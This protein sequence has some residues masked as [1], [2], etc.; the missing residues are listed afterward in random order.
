MAKK[1]SEV[2]SSAEFKALS[3]EDRELARNEYFDTVVAPQVLLEEVDMARSEFDSATK[4]TFFDGVNELAGQAK[5]N[6]VSAVTNPLGREQAEEPQPAQ[7]PSME[8]ADRV[9]SNALRSAAGGDPAHAATTAMQAE[10][11]KLVPVTVKAGQELDW[12]KQNRPDALAKLQT[13]TGKSAANAAIAR[14]AASFDRTVEAMRA[15]PGEEDSAWEYSVDQA[16]QLVG[17]GA[18]AVGGAFGLKNIERAG[19]EYAE[20]QEQDI[21]LGGYK[22]DPASI[23]ERFNEEGFVGALK[24]VGTRIAENWAPG[25]VAL[26]GSAAAALT[27]VFSAPAATV[28]AGATAG[29]AGLMGVGEVKSELED[30]G[31]E[32]GDGLAVGAGALI[33]LLDMVGAGKV[34]PRDMLTRMT[35]NEIVTALVEK[36]YVDAAKAFAKEIG[37]KAAYEGL[38][39]MAQEGV[40]MGAAGM[41]GAEYE[42]MEVIDRLIDGAVIGA[43]MGGG[44]GTV[45]TGVETRAGTIRREV[46]ARKAALRQELGMP[47]P[48]AQ[49]VAAL[50]ADAT[51]RI[52]QAIER[53]QNVQNATPAARTQAPAQTAPVEAP[54]P[55]RGD[56]TPA[57]VLPDAGGSGDVQAAGLT[58][59]DLVPATTEAPQATTEAAPVTPDAPV[60]GAITDEGTKPDV[61]LTNEGKTPILQN[62]NRATPSSIAQMQSIAG[63]PDYGRMGF[64]RDF[65]NGAPVVAGGQI[66]PE[67]LGRQDVAVASDGRRIPVQYA[68]VEAADVLPSNQADGTPNPDYGNQSVQRI[69]A[70]AGNGRI[71]GLQL[72]YRKGT[73]PSYLQELANDTLHGVS[74]DVIRAMR[75]PVLVRV[76]P[77]DQV[78]ADIGDVSNTVGNLNLSAVEQANNDSQRVNLDALQFAEDGSITPEAVRQFVRAMPQAEQGGLIDTNGQPS[79]QAVDRIN[80]AVFAKAYGNDQLVRLYAQAQDPEARNVLSALA[81]VAPKMARLEGAGALDIRG[82]V[83]QAAEIAVNARREGKALSLAAQQLDLAADPD[84]GKL[85]DLF[86]RNARTVKPVVE[87]LS[88]AA[89]FA[90][91]EANK[92]GEDMFGEVPRASRTDIINQLS[93]Q[94]ERASQE[95]LED[96]AGRQPVGQDAGRQTPE[97][98]GPAAPAESE[99]G[100]PAADQAADQPASQPALS[101]YTPEEVTQRLERLEQAERERQQQERQADQRERADRERDSFTLTGS[102]RAADANPGQADIFNQPAREARPSDVSDGSN[103]AQEGTPKWAADAYLRDEVPDGWYVHGRGGRQDLNTG[104]VIQMTRSWEVAD[105]YAKDRGSRWIIRPSSDAIVLDLS[106][107]HTSDMDRVVAAA[108]DDFETGAHD[109]GAVVGD[110]ESSIGRDADTADIEAAIRSSFSPENIVN[111]A[112]AYDNWSWAGWLADAL[113]VDFV[114]VKGGAVAIG[115]YAVDAVKVPADPNDPN[116]R[117]KIE[118]PSSAYVA[119]PGQPGYTDPYGSLETRP[120]TRPKQLEAGRAALADIERRILGQRAGVLEAATLLGSAISRD[121][122]AAGGVSLVGRVARTAQDLAAVAQVLRDP[123]FETFRVFYTDKS[124]KIVGERA[125]S[126][127][128]AGVTY[129]PGNLAALIEQDMARLKAPGY[130][131][132]HNHP[133]G[134]ARE[135]DADIKSTNDLAL[136]APGLLGHVIIDHN[137]YNH[138]KIEQIGG[139]TGEVIKAPELA[140]I[141]LNANHE[142]PHPLLGELILSPVHLATIGKRLQKKDGYAVLIGTS[143]NGKIQMLTEV[144]ANLLKTGRSSRVAELRAVVAIKRAAGETGSYRLFAVVPGSLAE[145]R[146]A[147]ESGLFIDVVDVDSRS[148]IKLGLTDGKD[149]KIP[150]SRVEQRGG[151]SFVNQLASEYRAKQTD[152]AAFRKWFGDS[153][154]VDANGKPLVVYHGGARGITEFDPGAVGS[155]FGYDTEGFFFTTERGNRPGTA[156]N[157]AGPDG[158]VYPVYLALQRPY[159]LEQFAA[160]LGLTVGD[161]VMQEG[162]PQSP[163][164]VFDTD[165]A[166]I[167]RRVR[168]G[169]YDGVAFDVDYGDGTREAMYVALQPTQVKS[170][171]G[172]RG[173]FDPGS[174]NIVESPSTPYGASPAPTRPQQIVS[175]YRAKQ[176]DTEAFRRWFKDSKVVDADGK[177]LVVYHGTGV[178]VGNHGE[179]MSGDFDTFLPDLSGKSSKTG[180]PSGTFFFTDDPQVASSYTVQW[181][182]DFSEKYKDNANVMPVYLSLKKPLKVSAKGENWRDILYKGEYRDINEIA[183]LAKESGKYDGVIVTRVKDHGVGRTSGKPSTTYI[184]FRPEQIK[185][186]TGNRGTFD[187][188]DPSIV[189]EESEAY[190]AQAPRRPYTDD[191]QLQ[192]FLDRGPVESQAG[193]AAVAAQRAAVSAVDDIR[194]TGTILGLALSGD[195]AA[196][197]RVSLVGQKVGSAE[198]LA[199][200]AQVYRDPRFETFRVVFV[201]DAGKVV[202]QVGLTSRLPAAAP[203]IMGND[204]DQYL[205]GLMAAARN[206]GASGYYMLHN[207][208][209]GIAKTS[210]ADEMLTSNYANRTFGTDVQFRGH[211]VIDTN[212]YSVINGRGESTLFK[213]DFGQPAPY[214]AQEWEDVSISGPADVM[215]M[216]KR[217]QVDDGAITLIHTDNQYRVKAIS[218]IPNDASTMSKQELKKL[219]LKASLQTQGA[220]VFA[221]GRDSQALAR[222]GT[223]VVDAIYVKDSGQAQSLRSMGVI[224]GGSP[225]PETR[226]ARLS[227]DS[228]PEFNY[229]RKQPQ[230]APMQRVAEPGADQTQTPEF[231]RWFGNSKV[232]DANGKPLVVYHGTDADF[233]EFSDDKI[234]AATDAGGNGRGFYFA[235]DSG[236]AS[237]YAG[238]KDGANIVPAY[239]S[240][241]NPLR[242]EASGFGGRAAAIRSLGLEVPRGDP[243]GE[244]SSRF[245]AAAKAKGYDGVL[246]TVNGDPIEVV[247]FRPEQIKSAIGNRGTFDPNDPSIVREDGPEYG[248]Q[249][250]SPNR[251]ALGRFKFRLGEVALG[252]LEAAAGPAL[253]FFSMRMASP[254]LRKQLR[255]M[256]ATIDKAKRAAVDVAQ[257]MSALSEADRVM[258]SDIVEKMLAPGVIP[259]EHVVRVADAITRSMDA[260]TDELVEL[261]ML[262]KDSAE[263]WRGRYLPRIY[264]RQTELENDPLVQRL[265]KTGVPTMAGIGGGSLK[266]R[267]MFQDVSVDAVDQW[268]ALGYEV[269]DP[270]WRLNQGKL[271]LNDP[272]APKLAREQVTVWRDWTPSERAQMGEM[273]DAMYRFVMGYTA[274]QRDIAL[275]RLFNNIANNPEWVRRSGSDG[276]VQVPNTEIPDTGGVKLYGNLAGLYVRRDVMSHLTQFEEAANDTLQLYREAMGIWKQGKVALNPVAHFNNIVSNLSMAH[277]AGVSYWDGHKY[278]NA[279]RDLIQNAP[280]VDEARDVG[281]FTGSFTREEM[282]QNLPPELQKMAN[283][284]ESGARKGGRLVLNAMTFWLRKPLTDAYEAEDTFFKYLIYR[285]ARQ[286]GMEPAEAMDYALRY[287]FAYDD[288]PSGARKVRD[289]A[290][291][292]FSYTYKA[293]PALLHT[294]MV[295]PWRLVAPAAL[296]HGINAVAYALA[297]GDEDDD[298]LEKLVKGRELEAEEREAMPDHTRGLSALGTPKTIRLGT[299]EL[300]GLPVF[301][302]ASRAIPGGDMFDM[303]N[304][305][306]GMELPAPLTPNHPILSTFAAM[307]VN[308]EMFLGRNV[309]DDNDT[310]AEKAE[311]RAKWM[312]ILLLPAIAPGGLHSQ[313]LMNATAN[314]M[315]TVITTPLGEFTGVDRSG[316]PVQPKYAAMQT[317]GIKARPVDL[318]LEAQRRGAQEQAL[319]N[320]IA[321]EVRSMARLHQR[322]AVTDRMM[323]ETSEQAREKIERTRE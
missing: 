106:G 126:S 34:I 171:I 156:D 221:V 160:D 257:E 234:G 97:P 125:Y 143:P 136:R 18:Q 240:L 182:G 55:A 284:Q 36:G 162:S 105:Q 147:V 251:D 256:K 144:P 104:N 288:L 103:T 297:A 192:L 92:P 68:V 167:M 217:L 184:A 295:Y 73:T 178:N 321:A 247:A 244:W 302:D 176:T 79:K 260:Q 31:I 108:L 82:V 266:G 319:V 195:Y 63:N 128:M 222:I 303:R 188:N 206:R 44:V 175:E 117:A 170:A 198:D 313:R 38:T 151:K 287:I 66:A 186:A 253:D 81:Q 113:G 5:D 28:L 115:D 119:Q 274:M 21:D 261:G 307:L 130:W 277:F 29:G 67:Q 197:Q 16:Q 24:L 211:V 133:S 245:T 212:E 86:A 190:N 112:E 62:R 46:E 118:A 32:G 218:T 7:Q 72:A 267:G 93:P 248:A 26:A 259:P 153:K 122:R 299:D 95:T 203:G 179:F 194:S 41:K 50:D 135:S 150:V 10:A 237:V 13:G 154:V 142:V 264:N 270:H 263:R 258:V 25:G 100:R 282:M 65:A 9:A 269:R 138:I 3:K 172:N 134:S 189:R 225:L 252:K 314:A 239:V 320:S 318:E 35:G 262:S 268:I 236:Y 183:Q 152:T 229:L 137:E 42:P 276:W 235:A 70:I 227:P 102:A 250:T 286:Q 91:T 85:L 181:R 47:E 111:S 191:R 15:K 285:D 301:L 300:T 226:R 201:N 99:A 169:G 193:A 76:M 233:S 311:K 98:A 232:V 37:K 53:A 196:R 185:S 243:S 279:V 19:R 238:K 216:A 215:A 148:A 121:F 59:D 89:D 209:S 265:F 129:Y 308:R 224:G 40:V 96:P 145:Y 120:N 164:T 30:K 220:Q 291:P 273:R 219:V 2:A 289:Y 168:E 23:R 293:V 290:I 230:P 323:D 204:I 315:D 48:V 304:Q 90:Y 8:Q 12:L 45:S 242:Y 14:G 173:T 213:K 316:L 187:P 74:H 292:F 275:G 52:L 139:A 11:R 33:G 141:D 210:R 309:T 214:R 49:P 83:T 310:A 163:I 272:N 207:H 78:T 166:E 116:I 155:N 51:N 298:W 255:Q 75:A 110:I 88:R 322:G 296:L 205:D 278:V 22:V 131:L 200:L 174:P 127:R 294:A 283:M 165:R 61:S 101:S 140:A 6:L 71:A 1:W 161:L 114:H 17:K 317:F 109:F 202:S 39:E 281:L 223:M 64:S 56:A 305:A 241:K 54:A 27:A 69:R 132:L 254:E 149:K 84:V 180:A 158:E 77:T 123:R 231:R 246:V 312:A 306:G 57:A 177:P 228:S 199:I 4:P 208:P 94:D 146:P 159:T 107:Q 124:G 80:A 58:F 60:D 20:Q 157:Y 87:A 43:A 249:R 280:M 271:E